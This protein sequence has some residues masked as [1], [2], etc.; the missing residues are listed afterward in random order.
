M[1]DCD[2]CDNNFDY[3]PYYLW[4]ADSRIPLIACKDNKDFENKIL[5]IILILLII[6]CLMRWYLY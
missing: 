3:P 5:A 6:S 1:T 4:V 2:L